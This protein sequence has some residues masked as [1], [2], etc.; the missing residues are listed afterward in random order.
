MQLPTTR[1]RPAGA[2]RTTPSRPPGQDAVVDCAVYVDGRRQAPVEPG[3]ALAAAVEQGG[4]VWLGLYEPT[5]DELES[6]A[7]RYGLH[8]LAVE[9]AVFAH[10]RPKLERYDEDLF[11]VLKTA[12]YV[13][14]DRLTATSEVVDTGEVMVFLGEHYVITVRHGRHG[15]LAELR[16]RLEEQRD[17][18]CLGPAAVLYAVADLVVDTFVEVADAVQD[19][20][21]ELEA[22]VFSPE[23]TDDIGRLY[24]LKRELMALRRAVAPLEVPLQKLSERQIDVVPD[25]MRSYFRDV[26][27]HAIRVRDAVTGLDEL[28]SS[29]LQASLARTQMADNED[30]RKI[31]AWAGIIA[32]PTAI[33]GIYGMNFE[34][35]PELHWRIGY[36]LVLLLIAVSC[37]W[38]YRGFK[39][40]GWL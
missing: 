11:M 31:S 30:M 26:Q 33:A 40:N 7:D 38:L 6:I 36:P 13:E 22:S 3:E 29:I 24:Q 25:A 20:V 21:D 4:Y 12:T 5:E 9:D 34:F 1:P 14:H 32:V 37:I 19:D 17:L 10:Q 15:D 18:L 16:H 27:D 39:R 23:R 35:M 2:P 8:P 28:L